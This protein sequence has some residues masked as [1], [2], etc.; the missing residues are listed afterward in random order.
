MMRLWN[1]FLGFCHPINFPWPPD[2][3]RCPVRQYL[4]WGHA[5][6]GMQEL[7]EK[8]EPQYEKHQTSLFTTKIPQYEYHLHLHT[9]LVYDLNWIVI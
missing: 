1:K 9:P 2:R 3:L 8:G 4:F 7:G 6:G 5:L